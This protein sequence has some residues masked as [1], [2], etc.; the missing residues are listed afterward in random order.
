M[1]LVEQLALV[2][3]LKHLFITRGA[4]FASIYLATH[5][6]MEDTDWNTEAWK[7]MFNSLMEANPKETQDLIDILKSVGAD[8]EYP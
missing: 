5:V 6:N 7:N 1:N 4:N 2:D 8:I 3:T